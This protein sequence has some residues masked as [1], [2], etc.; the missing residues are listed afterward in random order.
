M[1]IG[2]EDFFDFNSSK[3][4]DDA[5]KKIEQ[6]GTSVSGMADSVEESAKRT[7]DALNDVKAAALGLST[8]TKQLN[9]ALDGTDDKL[10][11]NAKASEDL[12]KQFTALKT[13][14]E[15]QAKQIAVLKDAVEKLAAAKKKLQDSNK[16]EYGSYDDLKIKLAEAEKAY[17]ALGTSASASV[18]DDALAKVRG[19]S[20]EF[21]N[22]TTALNEAKKGAMT[23]AGSY[24]ELATRVAAAKKQLKEMEGG[25]GGNSKEFKELKKFVADGTKQ[26]KEFD[27]AVGDNQRK[28]GD[29]AGE[30]G[31]ISPALGSLASGIDGATKASLAFIATP[32]G[33]VLALIAGAVAALTAYFN[34][35]IEGQDE[36]NKVV[37]FGVAIFETLKDV[38]ESVGKALY[39][40]LTGSGEAFDA[41][42]KGAS[43]AGKAIKD[44]FNDPIPAIKSFG[45]AI[46]DFAIRSLKGLAIVGKGVKEVFTGEFANGLKDVT[47]G[48]IQYATGIEKATDKIAAAMKPIADEIKKRAELGA[49]IAAAENQLRKD[50]IADI[51]DDAKTELAVTKLLVEARDKLRFSDEQRFNKLR[52]ANELLEDQLKGDLVLARDEVALQQLVIKQSGETYDAR[53]KL[54]ELQAKEIGLQTQFFQARKK[55]QAEEIALIREIEKE[56]ID[57]RQ[58]TNDAINA[59]NT[60]RL[61]DTIKDNQ[62]ILAEENS[63]LEDRLKAITENDAAQAQLIEQDAQVQLDAVK[64][65]GLARVQL[66]AD[67]LDEIYAQNELSIGQRIQ[68]ER[69]AKEML[70]TNDL[71]Y[72]DQVIKITEDTANKL[73]DLLQQSNKL[74]EDNVFKV[75]ARD[76]AILNDQTNETANNALTAVNEAFSGGDIKSVEEFEQ[77]KLDIQKKAQDESLAQQIDYLRAKADLLKDGS[78]EQADVELQISQLELKQSEDA[79]KQRLAYEQDLQSKLQELKQTAFQ[80]AVDIINNLFDAEEQDRQARLEKLQEQQDQELQMAGDNKEAQAD[81]NNKFAIQQKKIEAEQA[82]AARKRA[83]FQKTLAVIEIAINTAKGIGQALGSFPPPASIVLGA[84]VAA[85]GA[86]QVAAVLSK[87]IPQFWKGTDDAP[88]GWAIINEQGPERIVTPSG[89]Q[90]TVYSDGPTMAYIPRHSK[91]YTAGETKQLEE[92]ENFNSNI[93]NVVNGKNTIINVSRSEHNAEL[94]SAIRS[95]FGQLS[96]DIKNKKEVSINVTKE[97]MKMIEKQAQTLTGFL[98]D[99]Y[100]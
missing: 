100:S 59:L 37:Q 46:A 88:E 53:Q 83:I 52:K 39:E 56:M 77:R 32:L 58:R 6:M 44:A 16:T 40:V 2:Y 29:Y 19:L 98:S 75:M 78:K 48:V 63:S 30:L 23:A 47:D 51:L 10:A 73:D 11:T 92:M 1:L 87:P 67:T 43:D 62:R 80:G 8:A 72:S 91:I 15:A 12:V 81:I 64:E 14:E 94:E 50:R 99:Y 68:L 82:A 93:N 13:S 69:T 45:T 84:V 18:K 26:L 31:K 54:V 25:L 86:I 79:A 35:S 4:I 49:Q 97:G 74:A 34:G 33:S 89:K 41:L 17:K 27:N 21:K 36:L 90:H 96:N 9:P 3:P 65:A 22:V 66:D 24:N 76:A 61:N 71:V 20:A 60:V 28:V 38:L 85:I 5:I 42:T 7:A 55:R 57:S 70:L 95:G